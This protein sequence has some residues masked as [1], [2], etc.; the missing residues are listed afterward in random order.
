[1]EKQQQLLI[2]VPKITHRVKYVISLLFSH[3]LKIEYIL[4]TDVDKFKLWEGAKMSYAK[5][6]IEDELFLASTDLLF[7]R[8]IRHIDMSY[9]EF[10]GDVVFFP[11]Y[12]KKSLFP[13]DVFAASFYLVSRYE[14]Y[15]P[16][17]KDKYGRYN[18]KQS[19]AYK[20]KFL[21][22]PLINIWT[23]QLADKLK[24]KF[25]N[26]NLIYPEYKHISTIDI[27]A[28]WAF[29]NKGFLRILGGY[30]KAIKDIDFE[31]VKFKTK[32]L[33]GH[34]EDPFDS[35]SFIEKVHKRYWNKPI[36]FVLFAKYDENDKNTPTSSRN[37]QELVKALADWAKIGIHPS[38]NSNRKTALL[39]EEKKKLEKVL[40]R[41]I[42]QSRQ[43][44]LK[45]ELPQTYRNLIN[46]DIAEDYTMGYAARPGFRASIA[47][48]YPFY[49]LD[50]DITTKMMVFPFPIMDATLRFYLGLKPEQ[51]KRIY[52]QYI[53]EIKNVG[54][55][56]VSLWHNE[57]L[58]E[59]GDWK[60]WREVFIEMMEEAKP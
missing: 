11:V 34:K 16:Y 36:F 14:E 28:A 54:G 32:V 41:E 47:S 1:M 55:T 40:N 49:D 20:K 37:F 42:F 26:L 13:F 59:Y 21:H 53:M 52:K 24:E 27:D 44:F 58:S 57:S 18:V 3:I 4:T 6:P 56:F 23:H 19:M 31:L 38:Y 29:S 51:A 33:L 8:G 15:L 46:E 5:S 12:H 10:M 7:E 50:L 17:K 60:A 35:F 22:R 39:G 48:P 2:Y 30:F 43:H 9:Q 25:P 45:L